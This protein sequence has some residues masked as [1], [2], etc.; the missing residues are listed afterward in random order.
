MRSPNKK[1]IPLG[2]LVVKALTDQNKTKSELATEIGITPQYLSYILNGTR[3]GNK[4][5]PA[6]IAALKLDPDTVA[7]VIAA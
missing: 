6:I 2:Q 7:Q 3:P 4:Y 5:L 1:L